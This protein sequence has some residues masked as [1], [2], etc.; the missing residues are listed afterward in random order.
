MVGAAWL[1][2]WYKGMEGRVPGSPETADADLAGG[3]A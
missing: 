1:I 3:E 2:T